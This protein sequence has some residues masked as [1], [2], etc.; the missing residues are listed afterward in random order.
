MRHSSTPSPGSV[1]GPTPSVLPAGQMALP[2]GPGPVHVSRS[3]EPARA[4]VSPTTATFGRHGS[5][6]SASAALASCLESRLRDRLGSR[7]STLFSLTWNVKA[8]PSGR[9][10]LQ[11]RA[12]ALRTSGNG[13]TSSGS[14]I[15]GWPTPSSETGL[16]ETLPKWAARMMS[17]PDRPIHMPMHIVAKMSGW[18]TPTAM[19][20]R[21]TPEQFLERKRKAGIRELLSDLAHQVAALTPG[22][23]ATGSST[24]TA[25][26]DRLNPDH[27]RW[28]MGYPEAWSAAAPG[29]DSGSSAA[30]A[31]RSS[32]RS[33][34]SGSAP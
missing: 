26:C 29:R 21:G 15:A 5:S 14:W 32:R 23:P 22:S 4:L 31:T 28:L 25:S 6:S 12:A 3:R 17:S 10:I 16:Y 8:T 27:A 33:P 9:P 18:S 13:S 30:T 20:G 24:S 7:G 1:G 2:F 11:R 19:V 34:P